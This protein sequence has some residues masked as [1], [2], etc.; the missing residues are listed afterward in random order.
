MTA[1]NCRSTL[2]SEAP[3]AANVQACPRSRAPI[4]LDRRALWMR[5]LRAGNASERTISTYLS[6][7]RKA[8][9]V[10]GDMPVKNVN[11]SAIESLVA[12]MQ[13]AGMHLPRSASSFAPFELRARD[14]LPSVLGA[15]VRHT[16]HRQRLVGRQR[17]TLHVVPYPH[18]TSISR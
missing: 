1:T 13:D 14:R 5:S 2:A 15:L 7:L 10:I 16:R 11:R 8:A 12:S 4:L 17:L 9:E 6:A 18:T 3:N